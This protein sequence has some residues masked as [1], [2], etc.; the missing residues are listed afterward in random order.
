M[1]AY[2]TL[3][4]IKDAI[5]AVNEYEKSKKSKSIWDDDI[6][7]GLDVLTEKRHML[8]SAGQICPSCGGTGRRS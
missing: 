6:K 4:K 1:E 2:E 7:K 5:D 3:K 8:A